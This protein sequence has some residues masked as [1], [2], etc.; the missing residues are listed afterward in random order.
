MLACLTFVDFFSI[1]AQ[2]SALS[3]TANCCQSMTMDEF[4]YVRESLPLL[5]A[6]LNQHVR[7]NMLLFIHYIVVIFVLP[8]NTYSDWWSK[9]IEY[10]SKRRVDGSLANGLIYE[11]QPTGPARRLASPQVGYNEKK[12]KVIDYSGTN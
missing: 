2:R 9:I 8:H 3:I 1:S 10:P 12:P 4:H 6:R 7:I 11:I 5:T